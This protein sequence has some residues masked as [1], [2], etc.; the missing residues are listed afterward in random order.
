MFL[1]RLMRWKLCRSDQHSASKD[2]QN[3]NFP[4]ILCSY[5]GLWTLREER[6]LQVFENRFLRKMLISRRDEEGITQGDYK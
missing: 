2:I 6:K 1:S 5:G 4:Y 3:N